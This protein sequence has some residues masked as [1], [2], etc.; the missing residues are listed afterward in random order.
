MLTH[1]HAERQSGMNIEWTSEVNRHNQPRAPHKKFGDRGYD[2]G[3]R[4]L[5][6]NPTSLIALTLWGYCEAIV[7]L[8]SRTQPMCVLSNFYRVYACV[9]TRIRYYRCRDLE[10]CLMLNQKSWISH[11][12]AIRLVVQNTR[13]CLF[14]LL[15]R[16]IPGTSQVRFQWKLSRLL[17]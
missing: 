11:A 8:C 7:R 3:A 15:W 14:W 16:H 1:S 4:K 10:T 12:I 2:D 9:R 17:E 13:Q 5:L 6:I